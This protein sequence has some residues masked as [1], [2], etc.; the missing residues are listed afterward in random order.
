[1]LFGSDRLLDEFGLYGV[2]RVVFRGSDE[3][4]PDFTGDFWGE[5]GNDVVKP[6]LLGSDALR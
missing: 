4:I 3:E 5:G 2:I 1:M 6:S